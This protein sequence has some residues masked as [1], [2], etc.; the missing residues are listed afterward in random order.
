MSQPNYFA[1]LNSCIKKEGAIKDNAGCNYYSQGSAGKV[2]ES[3]VSS[4]QFT[5]CQCQD[6]SR[7]NES[8]SCYRNVC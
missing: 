6:V 5:Q 1:M 3:V 4:C 8:R 2:E 7:A